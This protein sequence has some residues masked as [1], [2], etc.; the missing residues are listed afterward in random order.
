MKILIDLFR[1]WRPG[2]ILL[3]NMPGNI[4][5]EEDSSIAYKNIWA[6][7]LPF[8]IAFFMWKI[9]KGKLPLDDTFWRMGYCISSRC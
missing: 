4:L 1:C 2:V 9:L 5:G 6:K 7:G 3:S 8:K